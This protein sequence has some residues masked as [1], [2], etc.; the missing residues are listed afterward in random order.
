ML[1]GE[2]GIDTVGL[3]AQ[4]PRYLP[5]SASP[6]AIRSMLVP[7]ATTPARRRPHRDQA[8]AS[9]TSSGSAGPGRAPRRR[10]RDPAIEDAD[11]GVPGLGDGAERLPAEAYPSGDEL[12][13]QSRRF[14]AAVT[15]GP[16]LTLRPAEAR[17]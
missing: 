3:S 17:A 5:A 11:D 8:G 6:P 12:G 4:V 9:P 13:L 2:T 14:A 15:L 10:R 7:C 1:L 16:S